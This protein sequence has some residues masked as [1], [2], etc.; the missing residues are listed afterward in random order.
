[1]SATGEA[2]QAIVGDSDDQ[3]LNLLSGT[4]IIGAIDLGEGVDT[5]TMSG[6]TITGDV[7][8]GAGA[9]VVNVSNGTIN[10]AFDIG[11]ALADAIINPAA[12]NTVH[13][14]NAGGTALQSE[15]ADFML[16][17]AGTVVINGNVVS[18]AASTDLDQTAGTLEFA[19]DS[20]IDGGLNSSGATTILDLST[21]DVT[22][23]ANSNIGAGGSTLKLKLSDTLGN[24]GGSLATSAAVAITV[25]D[26]LII[27]PTAGA[28]ILKQAITL[29]DGD[30]GGGTLMI[31]DLAT[32]QSNLVDN[33]ARLEFTLANPGEDLT[34]TAN[35]DATLDYSDNADAVNDEVD[36][37]FAGDS[38]LLAA[39]NNIASANELNEALKTLVPNVDGGVLMGLV[40]AGTATGEMVSTRLANLRTGISDL[41]AGDAWAGERNFWMQGF[42]TFADQDDREG[43]EGFDVAIG[44]VALGVD[45]PL[46]VNL[47]AGLVF[48]YA[49]TSVNSDSSGNQTQID[50]YQTT[51]YGTHEFG[52]YFLD[53]MVS[54][55]YNDYGGG[56]DIRWLA[57]NDGPEPSMTDSRVRSRLNWV[58]HSGW[59][60]ISRLP[61]V[62]RCSTA[63]FIQ[64]VTRKQVPVRRTWK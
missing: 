31:N 44:G 50:S 6:G 59:I 15:A 36:A 11:G 14:L 34:L 17:G 60:I 16:S 5:F 46:S 42:G 23:A 10:G 29:I 7:D 33:S 32:L 3:T 25:D 28:I 43:F 13:F 22:V 49:A 24:S 9:N 64:T 54:L 39:L 21:N 30:A 55:A 12:G 56:R 53:S 51:A 48:S 63:T 8:L 35:K 27:S 58:V 26:A 19:G 57:L 52:P 62:S 2:T 1:M 40:L 41:A 61:P 37:A 47:T 20:A 4:N 38:T 18:A 45:I